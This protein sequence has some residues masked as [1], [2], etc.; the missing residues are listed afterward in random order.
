MAIVYKLIPHILAWVGMLLLLVRGCARQRRAV[1]MVGSGGF[2]CGMAAALV[3]SRLFTG[4]TSFDITKIVLGAGFFLFCGIAVTALYGSAGRSTEI[5]VGER[6]TCSP[7]WAP[8]GAF[9]AGLLGGTIC[10]FRFVAADAAVMILA[11]LTVFTLFWAPLV[12][13]FDRKLPNSFVVSPSSLASAISGLLLFSSSSILRLDLFSP[14]TMK[15]MKFAHDFVHQFF[16]SMLIP[17]H[18][19]FSAAL[20]NFVGF[21]FGN[22]VG[23]WGALIVWLTPALLVV[24]AVSAE[25]LPSVAHLRQGARRRKLVAAAIGVR[26]QKLIVPLCAFLIFAGAIYKSKY[27]SV[28]YWDPKP[29]LVAA[30]PAGDIFIPK[31]SDIDLEDGKLHKYLFKQGEREAR[32][33]I[34]ITPEG[35][36]TAV[37]DACSICKP[38]GYGQA[39]GTVVCYY[40][41]TLIP[42]ETVGKPGGCNPVPLPF[43]VKDDGVHIDALTLINLWGDTVQTT[44]RIKGG[45]E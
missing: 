28:E 12:L 20:W 3:L 19:F 30:S 1:A 13:L 11:A 8:A 37:L 38:D 41:K 34:I 27:P 45:G 4:N 18:L 29:L 36:L 31:K 32:F 23:F 24:I 40:C 42:L 10:G 7:I 43:T 17:D 5:T 33:F 35:K 44:S 26:R 6:L 21:L 15:V 39:E 22:G 16:E 9:V 2:S 14:L 25:P